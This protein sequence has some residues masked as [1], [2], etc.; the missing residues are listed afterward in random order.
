[1]DRTIRGWFTGVD[2]YFLSFMKERE[3]ER[4]GRGMFW[5]YEYSV[6]LMLMLLL[7]GDW[8]DWDDWRMLLCCGCSM[9]Y[10]V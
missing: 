10:R 6:L 1:M 8:A 4:L 7:R 2:V 3:R 5:M 9:K